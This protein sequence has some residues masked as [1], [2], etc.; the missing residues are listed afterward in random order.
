[1]SAKPEFRF[2]AIHRPGHKIE[3]ER[4]RILRTH[5]RRAIVRNRKS[6]PIDYTLKIVTSD[7]VLGK[8]KTGKPASNKKEKTQIRCSYGVEAGVKSNKINS[9]TLAGIVPINPRI[10]HPFS[11][12][13]AR[14]VDMDL[15]RVDELFRS[16]VSPR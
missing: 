10:Y 1:M 6:K 7:D 11:T 15:E 16:S 13:A 3:A 5:V 8:K 12:Y 2:F 14:V 4:L 9:H